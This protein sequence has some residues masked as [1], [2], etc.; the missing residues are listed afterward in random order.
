MTALVG[1][2]CLKNFF[3]IRI[4]R[5]CAP[6]P[7][8]KE[9]KGLEAA[10]GGNSAAGPALGR[11]IPGHPTFHTPYYGLFRWPPTL[12]GHFGTKIPTSVL[13]ELVP[14]GA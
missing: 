3:A 12:F 1:T 7:D 5:F 4:H 2:P 10:G 13:I 8:N 9:V 11:K 6:S 14:V